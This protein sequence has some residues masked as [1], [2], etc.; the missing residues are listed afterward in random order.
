MPLWRHYSATTVPPQRHHSAT[1]AP[2]QRH[3]GA[4]T[5]PLWRHQWRPRK[6]SATGGTFLKMFNFINIIS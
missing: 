1:M 3:Y 6:K 5:A 2:P 4:T